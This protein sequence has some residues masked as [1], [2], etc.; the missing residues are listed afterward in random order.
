M[1]VSNACSSEKGW[2]TRAL[3]LRE[4]CTIQ[5]LH[6][7]LITNNILGTTQDPKSL[8]PFYFIF[9]PYK[10]GGRHGVGKTCREAHTEE[11]TQITY[12]RMCI[13]ICVRVCLYYYSF[14]H[15]QIWQLLH[16]SVMFPNITHL[17]FSQIQFRRLIFCNIMNVLKSC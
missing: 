10:L 3:I 17:F 14:P 6:C 1:R 11:I 2:R 13:C 7:L 15:F 12:T 5:R 8:Q 16:F 9:F 4:G